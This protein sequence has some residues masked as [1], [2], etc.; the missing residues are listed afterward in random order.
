MARR[1]F[2]SFHY[3]EDI[4]RVNQVRNS[5]V[6]KDWEPN[7]PVDHASWEALKRKGDDEVHKWIDKQLDGAGVTV[8]LIGAYTSTRKFVKYEVR[9]SSEL[10]KGILGIRIHNLKNKDEKTSS[11]GLNPLDEVTRKVPFYAGPTYMVDKKLSE[12]FKTYDYKTDNGYENF[13]K[14]VEESAKLAGR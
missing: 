6:T 7:T 10:N 4:W 5:W 3:D 2:F 8:V 12:I 11:Y 1:V 14:W 13:T 9:K